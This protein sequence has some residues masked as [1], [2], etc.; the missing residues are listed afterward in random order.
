[1]LTN[2]HEVARFAGL[3]PYEMLARAGIQAAALNHPENWLP[4]SRVLELIDDSANRS[5][6]D[7]FGIL[8]GRC[9]TFTSIGPL[10]LLLK[11]EAT[12]HDIILA[13]VEYRHL[14]NDVIHIDVRDD[15]RN[16]VVEW[17]L[18]PGLHS[19]QGA[20]LTAAIAYKSISEA[21]EFS[22]LPDCIH[23]RHSA[24][25]YISTFKSYF[26][27]PL[28]FDSG[29]DGMTCTSQALATANPFA[30]DELATYARRLLDLLPGVRVDRATDKVRS[31]LLL[32]IPDGQATAER[33]ARCLGVPVRTLQR[34][35]I[36]EGSGFNRLLDETRRELAMRYLANTAHPIAVVAHLTGYSSTSAFTRWFKSEFGIS[37][38]RWRKQ[39]RSN[40]VA[41]QIRQ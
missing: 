16:A 27:C 19:S 18:I 9:R 24:P 6:R 35:L 5:N 34:R 33:A 11:H 21:L 26:Q 40:E 17:S 38:I 14:L 25:A 13:A 41:R 37:P 12:V 23:F 28:E 2:Y 3:E 15:G 32:L 36:K 31:I 22:W 8:L 4:A 20:N 30:D 29:F 39:H 10:S 7:D 1:M